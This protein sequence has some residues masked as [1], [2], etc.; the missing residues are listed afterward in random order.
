MNASLAPDPFFIFL[1]FLFSSSSSSFLIGHNTC[2][3]CRIFVY[4]SPWLERKD[5]VTSE[6]GLGRI[7]PADRLNL[8]SLQHLM[9]LTK[10][11][12]VIKFVR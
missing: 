9:L 2:I 12:R 5:L 8:L 11:L 4:F 1:F 10:Q 3:A 6:T 7:P